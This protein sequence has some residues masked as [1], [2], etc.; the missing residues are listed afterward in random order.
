MVGSGLKTTESMNLKWSDIT[1]NEIVEE[2]GGKFQSVEFFK[3]SVSGKSKKRKC[4]I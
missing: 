4:L 2:V 3:T 1:D